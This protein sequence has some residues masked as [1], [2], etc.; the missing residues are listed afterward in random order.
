[1]YRVSPRNN[2]EE[3]LSSLKTHLFFNKKGRFQR[4]IPTDPDKEKQLENCENHNPNN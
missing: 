3:S 2:T 4:P 1:M